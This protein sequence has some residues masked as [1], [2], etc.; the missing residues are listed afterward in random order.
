MGGGPPNQRLVLRIALLI[1]IPHPYL[2][3]DS[4]SAINKVLL[5][6]FT[7]KNCSQILLPAIVLLIVLLTTGDSLAQSNRRSSR[8]WSSD[9]AGSTTRS[10]ARGGSTSRSRK[11]SRQSRADEVDV[12]E[13]Q[14]PLSDEAKTAIEQLA[15]IRRKII[16]NRK[17]IDKMFR[18]MPIGFANAQVELQK[19][20]DL[21]KQESERL[22][23]QLVQKGVEVFRLAP[24]RE[25]ASTNIVMAKLAESLAP[26][27]AGSNFDPQAAMEISKL[28]LEQ[29]DIS[30]QILMK[31]FKASYA[32]QDFEQAGQILDRLEEIAPIKDV[33]Y[34]VLEQTSQA[35][36]DELMI[37][38]LE[39]ATGDLPYA[40]VETTEGKFVIELFENQA[41]FTVYDFVSRAERGF[42]DDQ[43]F[44]LV[45]P[46]EFARAGWSKETR[47]PANDTISSEAQQEKA[48]KHFAGSVSMVSQDGQTTSS[49]FQ[50]CHQPNLAFNGKHTVFG[51]VVDFQETIEGKNISENALDIVYRLKTFGGSRFTSG[52]AEA[53][54]IIKITIENKRAHE[55]K[56]TIDTASSA[57]PSAAN[58][59][60]ISNEDRGNEASSFDLLPQGSTQN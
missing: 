45:K 19:E 4:L 44:F 17:R 22:Q 8:D 29:E 55:Y 50:I 15:E 9:R 10:S 39:T 13:S 33:Y 30:W 25:Q 47:S 26:K 57:A 1:L 48:R 37:R 24:L 34:E 58:N 59:S 18:E 41:T 42:Y 11:S 23:K 46:G 38:R 40:I 49:V 43:P 60:V 51:R 54:K 14:T 16:A 36:Q 32:V 27:S 56:L 31:A 21:A 52:L 3:L 6:E 35:W 7:M 12:Q 2:A 53:S 20:I 28:L 5:F